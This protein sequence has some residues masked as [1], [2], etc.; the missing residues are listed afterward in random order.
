MKILITGAGGALGGEFGRFLSNTKEYCEVVL[1]DRNQLDIRRRAEVIDCISSI[2]PDVVI[3]CAA[4][5][6]VIRAESGDGFETAMAVNGYAVGYLGEGA[7]SV[8]ATLVHFSTNYV[9]DGTNPAGYWETDERAPVNNYGLSKLLGERVVQNH[10]AKYYLIRTGFLYGQ[11]GSSDRAK[12]SFVDIMLEK[13]R[14]G[15]EIKCVADQYG[16]P[17]CNSDLVQATMGLILENATSGDYHI[18]NSGD[19]SRYDWAKV[20]F[21]LNG[22]SPTLIPISFEVLNEPVKKPQYG[23]LNNSRSEIQMPHWRDA[24]EEYFG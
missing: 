9:F 21:E 5:N 4:Y 8:G 2:S 24:L 14:A 11:R 3:N 1:V 17:T 18:T 10:S 19:A 16:Q 6:D 22:L 13:A 20:I 15:E 7:N 23:L 12:K